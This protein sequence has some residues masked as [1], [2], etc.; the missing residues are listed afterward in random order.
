[1][2]GEGFDTVTQEDRGDNI[3]LL[4]GRTLLLLFPCTYWVPRLTLVT[5]PA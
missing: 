1:M 3:N 2:E 4:C 5:A